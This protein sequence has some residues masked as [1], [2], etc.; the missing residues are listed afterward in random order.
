MPQP[1]PSEGPTGAAAAATRSEHPFAHPG[2]GP[3]QDATVP[4]TVEPDDVRFPMLKDG[5]YIDSLS[6]LGVMPGGEVLLCQVRGKKKWP[7]M[8]DFG[9]FEGVFLSGL[10]W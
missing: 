2:K 3:H 1:I 10:G 8:M 6:M 4:W 9:L 7:K 5:D